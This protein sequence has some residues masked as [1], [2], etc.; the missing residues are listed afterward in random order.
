MPTAPSPRSPRSRSCPPRAPRAGLDPIR[1]ADDALAIVS[2]A[3]RDPL[4]AETLA[5]F[6]DDRHCGAGSIVAV[7]DTVVPDDV[8][9]VADVICTASAAQVADGTLT[10]LVV[11]SCRRRAG[12]LPDDAERWC[13]LS[14]LVETHGL[15]LVEWF[16]VGPEGVVLP[17]DVAGEP[18]RW[19]AW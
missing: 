4:I 14:D 17:R 11:A 9:D 10:G 19:D 12:L 2:L 16:V 3:R 13:D 5:F 6:L 8:L 1:S 18:P 7:S 15:V